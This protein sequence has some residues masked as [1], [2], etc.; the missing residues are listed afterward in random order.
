MR[1]RRCRKRKIALRRSSEA[2]FAAIVEALARMPGVT[3]SKP[4]RRLFGRSSLKAHDK[5]LAM[6]SSSGEFVVKVPK[7]RVDRLVAA[8]AA[9]DSTPPAAAP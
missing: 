3:H 5:I 7:A 6:V 4:G 2:Q 8:G 9:I 1:G